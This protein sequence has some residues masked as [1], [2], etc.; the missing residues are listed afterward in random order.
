M[1]KLGDKILRNLEEQVQYLTNYHEVNQGLVQWGIRVVGQ[2][3]SQ[4]DLPD[5]ATYQGE[6]GDAIAVGTQAPFFF[7]IW[8]RASI[9]GGADYWFSFGRISIIGPQGPKGD[10]GDKGDTGESSRWYYSDSPSNPREGDM[11]LM[12]NGDVFR[13]QMNDQSQYGWVKMTNI[14]G[15]QGVQGPAGPAGPQGVPGE[16]GEKG[17]TGD[18]GGFINIH[19]IINNTAQLPTP[20]S[21]NNLTIA[22]LVGSQSPYDLWVQVGENSDVAVWTNTGPFNAGT[23][24]SVNGKSQNVWDADTKLDKVTTATGA[25]Q[26]YGKNSSGG[27]WMVNII[28]A[29]SQD[30][31]GIPRRD[32]VDNYFATKEYVDGK[33]GVKDAT[34][35]GMV[36]TPDSNGRLNIKIKSTSGLSYTSSGLTIDPL[37]APAI[38][39]RKNDITS[40]NASY[41]D[42]IVRDAMCDGKGA[43]W[44]DA[45][46]E[47]ACGRMG[48]ATKQYVDSRTAGAYFCGSVWY[49]GNGAGT[50]VKINN[51]WIPYPPFRKDQPQ[52]LNGHTTD[53]GWDGDCDTDYD[54]KYSVDALQAKAEAPSGSVQVTLNGTYYEY[55]NGAA[56]GENPYVAHTLDNQTYN[57]VYLDNTT[58]EQT[59]D[60]S[61][62]NGK[63]YYT[64]YEA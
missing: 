43:A 53:S 42:M 26:L 10:K 23:L 40:F 54:I 62:E 3:A 29:P 45:E 64:L 17:D 20:A 28:T 1:I 21:L 41:I 36:I 61:P 25:S 11:K 52:T 48:A 38:D 31:V 39:Q 51:V 9:E 12:P 55:N 58:F 56:A 34:V 16:K 63:F 27:Q 59:V 13:Y 6:Y 60:T 37:Y 8:T 2:V 50:G 32:Y 5:P 49:A 7:Y 44:T 47:A 46:K 30:G 57:A 4:S 35:G 22:Y 33:S 19:G 18:V 14:M 24:V 15:P